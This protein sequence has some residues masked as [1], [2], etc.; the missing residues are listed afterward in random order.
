MI[1]E[2][3][4]MPNPAVIKILEGLLNDAKTGEI[5]GVA[6]AGAMSNARTFNVYELGGDVMSLLGEVL[7]LQRDIMDT[8]ALTRMTPVWE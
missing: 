2:V 8:N 4:A 6:I 5:Q 7:V 1:E 3:K